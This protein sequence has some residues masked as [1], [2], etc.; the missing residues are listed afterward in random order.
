M[1]TVLVTGAGRGIG[2][3]TSL[4]LAAS[5]WH[6]YAGVRKVEDGERLVAE[7]SGRIEPVQVDVTDP[8]QVAAAGERI[9]SLDAL[10]N[11]AGIV[12]GGPVEGV[13]LAD[14]RRQLEVNVVGQVAVT[15]ALLPR[16]R[17]SRGRVVF[18]SSVSGRVATPMTGAYNASKF[19]LEGLADALRM[20]VHPWRIGVSLV[21]PAQTD[22]DMW[23]DAEAELDATV[24]S[25]SPEHR[26]LYDAHIAGFRRMI[27]LSQRMASPA[28]KVASTIERALTSRRPRARYVVGAGPKLQAVA[29][30]ATPTPALD[31]LLRRVSGVPRSR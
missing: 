7:S 25:L 20:E 18:V 16:L 12:V 4:R 22:T 31:A 2:R 23:Q 3:T 10:V 17:E 5:G 11:N 14:L 8:D 30:G 24:A 29:A 28:E 9:T 13:P 19:A 26:E 27:P 21:E 15:Q 1:R 6:V